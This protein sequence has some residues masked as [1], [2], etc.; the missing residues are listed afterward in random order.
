MNIEGD[1]ANSL[2]TDEIN[3]LFSNSVIMGEP[4]TVKNNPKNNSQQED[5]SMKNDDEDQDHHQHQHQHHQVQPPPQP[6]QS[7]SNKLWP[8]DLT[9]T[10]CLFCSIN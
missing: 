7:P 1:D 6:D 2:E 10:R 3:A 4:Q 8:S 5:Q 9:L